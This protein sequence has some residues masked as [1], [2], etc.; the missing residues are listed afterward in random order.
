[1]ADRQH[2]AC[3]P[4]SILNIPYT[5]IMDVLRVHA[6]EKPSQRA[7]TFLADGDDEELTITYAALDAQARA[8][9]A[10]LQQDLKPGDR[11][12]MLFAP[13][14]E[15]VAA[16]M[17]CL[18]AGVIAVPAY[19]PDPTRLRQSLP[20][21]ASIVADCAPRA[22]L[23]SGMILDFAR[24]VMADVPGVSDAVWLATDAVPVA[25]A[26]AWRD[27]QPG[28]HDLAFLQYTSGSTATP[29]GVMVS[30]WHL[31][32]NSASGHQLAGHDDPASVYVSWLPCYHD[33]GLIGGILQPMYG[34]FH[35][36]LMSPLAFLQ[37]PLRWLKAISKYRGTT[38]PFPNFAL[39]LCTRKVK[40]EE[41]DAL[42]LSSWRFAVNGAEPVRW[43]SVK[44]FT[45][46]FAPV[47][48]RPEVNAPAYGLAEATLM[49]SCG[50]AKRGAFVR[51]FDKQ[52]LAQ[53][54]VV[55][56]PADD[57]N[58][59]AHVGCGEPCAEQRITIVDPE[60][61]I[62]C[63]PGEAGEI[64]VQA[65]SVAAGYWNRPEATEHTFNA[66]LADT[67]EGPFLRT[68]DLGFLHEGQLFVAGR[69]KDLII[70]DGKNH[71]PQDIERSLERAHP[72]LR[73]GCSAA[74]SIDEDG[75]EKLAVVAEAA[76]GEEIAAVA[77]AIRQAVANEHSVRV[78]DVLLI[79]TGA[80]PKT[81]SGKIQRHACKIGYLER[82]LPAL[83]N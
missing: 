37:R 77:T 68:G 49:V 39:D 30:H 43:E 14:L 50:P 73:V 48:F 58:A 75:Q 4:P 57:A 76:A 1:M 26:A 18:Y 65:P 60:T 12:I 23:T 44:R 13:G 35:G 36:V 11:A 54:K 56:A 22:I 27:P 66:R 69:I 41:R 29:R 67:G 34:G 71:Y 82:K 74:F 81:S 17:G 83:E 52:E 9:A 15:Y 72:A 33:M 59:R 80:I 16:Y 70:I 51:H 78:H 2:A 61:C 64:W 25:D 47:G 32:H 45:E 62:A 19:P 21:V 55:L 40:P 7:Y 5:S 24:T 20:R 31:L 53:R 38:S 79:K 10:R 63:A 8:I 42:D 3:L 6:A 28:P 46:Y